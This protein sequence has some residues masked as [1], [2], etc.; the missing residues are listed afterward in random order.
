M[1]KY[2]EKIL[3]D[4]GFKAASSLGT[5]HSSE[6]HFFIMETPIKKPDH[7]ED[8]FIL[9]IHPGMRDLVESELSKV[10]DLK[11]HLGTCNL[12]T[13]HTVFHCFY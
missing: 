1:L 4:K 11:F 12:T 8:Y 5:F 9:I 3:L 2:I 6:G 7:R 13:D 10:P